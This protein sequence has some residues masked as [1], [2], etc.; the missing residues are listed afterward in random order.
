MGATPLPPLSPF[1]QAKMLILC[2]CLYICLAA[3]WPGDQSSGGRNPGVGTTLRTS[4]R[5]VD[6]QQYPL[7]RHPPIGQ[8]PQL[9]LGSCS[10]CMGAHRREI[11]QSAPVDKFRNQHQLGG[12][13]L[14]EQ[15]S[16]R[17]LRNSWQS[18]QV[19][20][21]GSC[22]SSGPRFKTPRVPEKLEFTY[23][24]T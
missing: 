18:F 9:Y 5:D 2:V 23:F 4:D 8:D 14:G 17:P 15:G 12:C 19:Q 24:G 10:R 21:T 11:G 20:V 6:T 3:P 22:P 13:S 16:Q 1:L 7:A